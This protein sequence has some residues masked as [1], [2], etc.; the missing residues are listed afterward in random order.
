[1]PECDR[2]G[3]HPVISTYLSRTGQLAYVYI[4]RNLAKYKKKKKIY[5]SGDRQDRQDST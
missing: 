2:E 1:M 3:R 4:R 5:Q